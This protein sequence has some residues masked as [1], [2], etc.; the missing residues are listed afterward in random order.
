[1]AVPL[2]ALARAASAARGIIGKVAASEAFDEGPA[3][4]LE[5]TKV[6]VKDFTKTF[7]K[8]FDKS[9]DDM[10]EELAFLIQADVKDILNLRTSPP[11]SEGGH[12]PHKDSGLL[13][14]SINVELYRN[15][16]GARIGPGGRAGV[17]GEYLEFGTSKMEKRPYL[18]PVYDRHEKE[19]V[20][21]T[22][23]AFEETRV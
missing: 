14:Q 11:P 15:P 21:L 2:I 10:V 1:M 3:I 5:V 12:P 17:Y 8:N 23:K 4:S 18:R 6:V 16:S 19:V 9:I 22:M 13:G 7:L 20:G